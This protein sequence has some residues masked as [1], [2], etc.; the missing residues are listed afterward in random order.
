[1][2]SWDGPGPFH[3]PWAE[4]DSQ[5]RAGI[6]AAKRLAHAH[7]FIQFLAARGRGG[8]KVDVA[9]LRDRSEKGG[10]SWKSPCKQV[11]PPA[12]ASVPSR[13]KTMAA[14]GNASG[15]QDMERWHFVSGSIIEL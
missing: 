9:V 4:L 7:F 1:L 8:D 15:T 10:K 11:S 12:A 3:S 6:V 2:K 14:H 13:S 5:C